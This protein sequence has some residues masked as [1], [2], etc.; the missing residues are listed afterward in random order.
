MSSG[1]GS[2]GTLSSACFFMAA[3]FSDVLL[4]RASLCF[5][6]MFLIINILLGEERVPSWPE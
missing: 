4:V 1:T 6:Y 5:A 3:V 2:W